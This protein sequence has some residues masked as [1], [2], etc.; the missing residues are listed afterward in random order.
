MRAI[1]QIETQ[2]DCV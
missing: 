1:P 2:I